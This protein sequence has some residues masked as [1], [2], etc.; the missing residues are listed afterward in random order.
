VTRE[1]EVARGSTCSRHDLL[2]LLLLLVSKAVLLL[3]I[4]LVAGVILI[5]VVVIVGGVKLL[6]LGAIGDEVSG[7]TKLE[8]APG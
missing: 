6:L 5:G 4:A 3:A 1:V 7:V 2:E 8:A